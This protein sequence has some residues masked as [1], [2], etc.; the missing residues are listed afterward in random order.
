MHECNDN[1]CKSSSYNY[2]DLLHMRF[3]RDED[4]IFMNTTTNDF[5]RGYKVQTTLVEGYHMPYYVEFTEPEQ[6]YI[7]LRPVKEQA[8]YDKPFEPVRISKPVNGVQGS[9]F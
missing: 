6:S 2:D 5:Y 8:K 9:L 1:K 4:N 7:W 3:G